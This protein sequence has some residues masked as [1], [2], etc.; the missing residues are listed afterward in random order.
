MLEIILLRH[1]QT[2]WNVNRKVMGRQPI[3]IND[4]GVAQLAAVA[5]WLAPI[6]IDALYAGSALRTQQSAGIIAQRRGLPVRTDDAFVE[7]DY[8]DWINLPFD[9]VEPTPAFH[10]YLFAPRGFTI[11]GGENIIAMQQRAVAGI[12][13]IRVSH[14]EGRVVACS[15]ADVI[16]A[17]LSHYMGLALNNWQ[18]LR[19]DNAS[20]SVLQIVGRSVRMP[21]MNL[22]LE[23]PRAFGR[24]HT[25]PVQIR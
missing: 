13:R 15:H 14:P 11:P 6:A 19:I 1:G 4:V 10:D 20:I 24:D 3:P 2:D 23:A 21:V 18:H 22:V 9:A 8:G 12:D 17:I 16:K 7:V 5:D 25:A